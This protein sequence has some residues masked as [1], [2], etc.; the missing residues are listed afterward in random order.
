M[1][2]FRLLLGDITQVETDAIV[3]STSSSL[4]GGGPVHEAVHRAAGP[5]LARECA[6]LQHCPPGEARV[7]A[8]YNLRAPF[9]IHTVPPTWMGGHRNELDILA[10]CYKSCLHLAETRGL[11]SVAF[12]SLGSG[13]QPQIPLE[14]AAPVVMRTLVQWVDQH[15]LP[16]QVLFVCMDPG[17]FQIHQRALREM[18]P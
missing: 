17:T 6:G 10:E 14:S 1:T 3:N 13:P 8:G 7:T 9:V 11:K 16:E 5:G 2:R 4:Q 18:L 15:E 12:P